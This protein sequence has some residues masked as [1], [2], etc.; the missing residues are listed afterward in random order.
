[1]STWL[2]SSRASVVGRSG[3]PWAKLTIASHVHVTWPSH[4]LRIASW[5]AACLAVD[6]ATA[7]A[8]WCAWVLSA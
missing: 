5:K 4:S 6:S 2:R 3:S 8:W 7:L 1:M